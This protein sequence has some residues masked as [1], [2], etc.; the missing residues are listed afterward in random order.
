[1]MDLCAIDARNHRKIAQDR[2]SA[3]SSVLINPKPLM[4]AP[5]HVMST[6][7]HPGSSFDCRGSALHKH[8]LEV[9]AASGIDIDVVGERPPNSPNFSLISLIFVIVS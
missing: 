8:A 6:S 2:F 5:R 4:F 7:P 3:S 1:M 9:N